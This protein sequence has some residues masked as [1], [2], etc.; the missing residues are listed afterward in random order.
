ME[1]KI[2]ELI[3]NPKHLNEGFRLLMESYR[4]G[5]YY[6]IRRLVVSHQDAEDILQDTFIL[7][8]KNISSF[9]GKSSLRTWIYRI[10]SN[11]CFALFRKRK[12]ESTE[13]SDK[14]IS[15]FKGDSSIDFSSIEAKFQ[16]AILSLPEKQRLAFTLRYYD[17]M[18][19]SEIAEITGVTVGAL[20]S[21]YHYAEKKLKEY[22]LNILE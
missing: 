2:L 6:H 18:S 22:M 20:K 13:L 14:L 12:I 10:A 4:E 19:Y 17:E 1:Q 8:Y 16:L 7:V 15:I 11:E 21:N 5:L 9:Q 3:N